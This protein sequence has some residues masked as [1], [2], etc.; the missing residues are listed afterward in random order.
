V[1]TGQPLSVLELVQKFCAV[2]NIKVKYK[3]AGRRQGDV[4]AVWANTSL[5]NKHLQWKAE[6]PVEETLARAWPGRKKYVTYEQ[7]NGTGF[8]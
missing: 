1:G 7:K 3:M 5:A 2:N 8:I 4:E 6:V